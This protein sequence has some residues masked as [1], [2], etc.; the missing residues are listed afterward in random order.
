MV[1]LRGNEWHTDYWLAC[2]LDGKQTLIISLSDSKGNDFPIGLMVI[3]GECL[4]QVAHAWKKKGYV[5]ED[6]RPGQIV[7]HYTNL[8][9]GT[10]LQLQTMP[11][12]NSSKS[13][14]LLPYSE[15]K[16]IKDT[17]SIRGDLDGLVKWPQVGSQVCGSQIF[18]FHGLIDYLHLDRLIN[19]IDLYKLI[20]CT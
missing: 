15:H 3:K 13:W 9:I 12:K 18:W 7:Y 11:N 5:F 8:V 10:N 1:S 16:R 20:N 4:T 17:I 2:C 19:L 14:Y 6:Y